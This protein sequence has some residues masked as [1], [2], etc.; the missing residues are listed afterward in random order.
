LLNNYSKNCVRLTTSSPASPKQEAPKRGRSGA[1]AGMCRVRRTT[2]S[3]P[4]Q[5]WHDVASGEAC[6][7]AVLRTS[8]PASPKIRGGD[9][10]RGGAGDVSC[11]QYVPIA[12]LPRV[13]WCG[14]WR[15]LWCLRAC[16]WGVGGV[17]N[18]ASSTYEQNKKRQQIVS[19]LSFIREETEKNAF[20]AWERTVAD[21]SC[22][23]YVPIAL[24]LVV[25]V[26]VCKGYY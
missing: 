24:R 13:A 17:P 15:G 16:V 7:Y 26:R 4:S 18:E 6:A 14:E 11:T 20:G 3:P 12:P 2:P 8:S 9:Q 19:F 25:Y 22:T 23:P 1:G 5:E 10:E 21:G